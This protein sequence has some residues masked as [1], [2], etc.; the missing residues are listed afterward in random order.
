LE[1][2]NDIEM[3]GG[4]AS[5]VM[6]VPGPLELSN[7]IEVLSF[8]VYGSTT[9]PGPLELSNS[10]QVVGY[11]PVVAQAVIP[12]PLNAQTTTF[13]TF[14]DFT[15]ALD[16]ELY[17]TYYTCVV[18]ASAGFFRV[19]I[20]SWQSTL[21][22]GRQSYLQAV[23]PGADEYTAAIDAALLEGADFVVIKGARLPNGDVFEQQMSRAPMG[24]VSTSKGPTSVSVTISGYGPAFESS[25]DPNPIFDRTLTGLRS[26][27]LANGTTRSRSDIDWLLQPAQRAYAGGIDY[28]VDY[29]NYYVNLQDSYMDTGSRG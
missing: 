24:D 12:G 10:I 11:F 13:Q 1:L 22:V 28:V 6:V 15:T 26:Q 4:T 5:A 7:S 8:N 23:V 19:P 27:S 20:S 2:S 14:H 17:Q 16:G 21:Q 18:E 3:L 29:V 9:V 25:T